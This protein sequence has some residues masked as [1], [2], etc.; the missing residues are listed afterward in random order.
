MEM[1]SCVRCG[2]GL[3]APQGINQTGD[4]AIAIYIVAKTVGMRPRVTSPAQRRVFCA[5]CAVAIAF[6][7]APDNGAFNSAIYS[8][9]VSLVS[10][11]EN[12][13]E[14]AWHQKM[15]PSAR[16]KL[17]PGSRADHSLSAPLLSGSADPPSVM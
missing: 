1:Q 2:H 7:P 14:V 12:V 6:G 5:P 8:M 16:R 4:P 3:R 17:M 10:A 9:L 11:G 13:M 15:N